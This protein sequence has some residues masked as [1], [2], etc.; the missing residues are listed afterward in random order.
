MCPKYLKGN[1]PHGSDVITWDRKALGLRGF[2]L[3][4]QP[5]GSQVWIDICPSINWFHVK[6]FHN[7]TQM[8]MLG[9]NASDE[10]NLC[11]SSPSRAVCF[12]DFRFCFPDSNIFIWLSTKDAEMHFC[13]MQNEK[14]KTTLHFLGKHNVH[15][16]TG[17]ARLSTLVPLAH[18]MEVYSGCGRTSDWKLLKI[19]F[20]H[21]KN[22]NLSSNALQ[23]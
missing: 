14:K 18:K 9:P 6:R 2:A 17:S 5:F 8:F 19:W 10:A 12:P 11:S 13:F 21:F 16:Q 1:F 20:W 23:S 15:P 4:S 3:L 7:N 22:H